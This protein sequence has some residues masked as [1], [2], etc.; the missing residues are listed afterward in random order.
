MS[1]IAF[2]LSL[3]VIITLF[4]VQRGYAQ[5][6]RFETLSDLVVKDTKSG[7]MWVRNANISGKAATKEGADRL[8]KDLND[9]KY[10]GYADW[11]LPN[12][13]DFITLIDYSKYRPALPKDQTF[14]NLQYVYITSTPCVHR[15]GHYWTV[16]IQHG[17]IR[18]FEEG[19][20]LYVWP[21]RNAN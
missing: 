8:L 16:N 12:I 5:Q 11:R 6:Q 18:M 15:Q 7:L 19:T 9:N 20:S 3:F 10:G 14:F 1:R 17:D 21:V 4:S 2:C 13:Y